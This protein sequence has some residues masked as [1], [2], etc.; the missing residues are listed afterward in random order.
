MKVTTTAAIAALALSCSVSAIPTL[1]NRN[2]DPPQYNPQKPAEPWWLDWL[3]SG[4]GK[5]LEDHY[6]GDKGQAT[7]KVDNSSGYGDVPQKP[8]DTPT[9]YSE[10]KQRNLNDDP[11]PV[12]VYD[13]EDEDEYVT[14]T[15]LPSTIFTTQS[16]TVY[17][18]PESVTNCALGQKTVVVLT[19]VEPLTTTIKYPISSTEVI[20]SNVA[21]PTPPSMT[22]ST[23]G[24]NEPTTT[25]T[26]VAQYSYASYLLQDPPCEI[27]CNLPDISEDDE[28][29]PRLDAL[30]AMPED[31][32]LNLWEWCKCKDKVPKDIVP[33]TSASSTKAPACT[34]TPTST[35][36]PACIEVPTCTE[37]PYKTASLKIVTIHGTRTHYV[38]VNGP[39]VT[40]TICVATSKCLSDISRCAIQCSSLPSPILY[41]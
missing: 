10:L 2:G 5:G 15:E 3:K 6:G 37:V 32:V 23:Q 14:E 24:E 21:E 11:K 30:S 34:D 33:L 36:A 26:E 38:T 16:T 8:V 28:S 35:D 12:V 9:G 4:A 17:S 7:Q 31:F 27:L 29:D 39:P 40:D 18:C 13:F 41:K 1:Q 20:L 25:D 22:E 19:T